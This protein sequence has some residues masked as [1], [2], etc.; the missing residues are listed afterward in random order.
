M[1]L[2]EFV[3]RLD[4]HPPA[5]LAY[6]IGLPLLAWG[7]GRF[8]GA[9]PLQDSPWRW[10]YSAIVFGAC[11]P[12]LLAAAML[13]DHLARGRLLD[14]S[15][16]SELLPVLTMLAV[17]FQIRRLPNPDAIPGFRRLTGLIWLLLLTGLALFLLMRTRIWVFFGGSLGALL[18]LMAGLFLAL[19]WAFDR[20]SGRER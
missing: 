6:G 16:Y 10:L 18:L 19:Q 1:T 13:A 12:G 8:R 5:M 15:I 3:A 2:Q 14:I 9:Q 11:V 7:I 4:A 20:M 17:L